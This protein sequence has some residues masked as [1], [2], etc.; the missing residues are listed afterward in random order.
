[1]KKTLFLLLALLLLIV[2]GC[3]SGANLR[4][5]NRSNHSLYVRI[6]NGATQVIPAQGENSWEIATRTQYPLTNVVKQRV[7]VGIIGETYHMYDEYEELWLDETDIMLGVGEHRKIYIWP[8]RA[9]IK[10]VNHSSQKID[11]TVILKNDFVVAHSYRVLE[12]VAA[13]DSTFVRVD[14][15]T[16]GNQFYYLV[17]LE[18]EGGKELFYGTPSDI[19][20][21]D[22][23][24]RIVLTDSDLINRL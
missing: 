2:A 10:I 16:P 11:R 4:I 1:M 17:K 12:A 19:L 15:V 23:Q 7:K 5:I 21:I 24:F 6:D 20:G 14:Y 8:N 18:M 13:G 9:S 22:Q 3:D